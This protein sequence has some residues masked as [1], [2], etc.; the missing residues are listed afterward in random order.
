[1]VHGEISLSRSWLAM[2]NR[3]S[4]QQCRSVRTGR[5]GT[6]GSGN[7]LAKVDFPFPCKYK[8]CVLVIAILYGRGVELNWRRIGVQ[9]SCIAENVMRG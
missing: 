4:N 5:I 3:L 8:C 1:M 2:V 6:S 9:C 7:G